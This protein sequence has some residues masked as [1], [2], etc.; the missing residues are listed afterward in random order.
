MKIE[1]SD[2]TKL[3]IPNWLVVILAFVF[4]MIVI[5]VVA[6]VASEV[7]PLLLGE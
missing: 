2:G 3:E 4:T 6:I 1:W 7:L 5:P